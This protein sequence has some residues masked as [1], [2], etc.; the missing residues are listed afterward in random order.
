MLLD[1]DGVIKICD[2]GSSHNFNN[3]LSMIKY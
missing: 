1:N 3:T 2:F